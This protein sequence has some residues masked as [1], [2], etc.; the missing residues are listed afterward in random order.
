LEQALEIIAQQLGKP[1]QSIVIKG[2]RER[3]RQGKSLSTAMRDFRESFQPFEAALIQNGE[4]RGDLAGA[5]A[6][7]ADLAERT[8]SIRGRL[9]SAM[10][11]P[12]ILSLTALAAILII[13]LVLAPTISPMYERTGISPPFAFSALIWFSELLQHWGWA[14]LLLIAVCVVWVGRALR[15]S[16]IRRKADLLAL[17]LPVFG[18]VVANVEAARICRTLAL[19]L[20]AGAPLSDALSEAPRV[21]TNRVFH[22]HFVA[23]RESVREGVALSDSL[24]NMRKFPATLRHFIAVGEQTGRLHELL[25]HGAEHADAAAARSLDRIMTSLSPILTLVMG[26]IVGT[27][28]AVVLS[29]ILG[30]NELLVE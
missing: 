19:L 30:A 9:I 25:L 10:I 26:V 11:Y 17:S 15:N 28:I 24:G 13:A 23:A 22:D 14:I 7:A 8:I 12:A 29:A 3:V 21:T 5:A 2:L 6:M 16:E 20:R 1:D 27:L 4:T 18:T